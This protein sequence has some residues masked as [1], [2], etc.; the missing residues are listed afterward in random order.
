M[1]FDDAKNALEEFEISDAYTN[2][3]NNKS[4]PEL[5]IQLIVRYRLHP[6]R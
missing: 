1:L 2:L 5:W 4:K 3:K 6:A